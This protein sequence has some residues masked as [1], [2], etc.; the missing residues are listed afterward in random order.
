MCPLCLQELLN[1]VKYCKLNMAVQGFNLGLIPFA[2]YGITEII[3][4]ATVRPA[5]ASAAPLNL[6]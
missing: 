6:R 1:A 5:A 3:K 2:T 4:S